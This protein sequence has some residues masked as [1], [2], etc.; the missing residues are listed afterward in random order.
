[1]MFGHFLLESE[2]FKI[3]NKMNE[4]IKEEGFK[5]IGTPQERSAKI[6]DE[7]EEWARAKDYIDLSD[8]DVV[9][10]TSVI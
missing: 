5:L 4:N 7:F 6:D 10:T 2:P 9:R 1:Y 8:D 3:E